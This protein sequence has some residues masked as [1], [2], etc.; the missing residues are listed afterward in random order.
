MSASTSTAPTK[1]QG[2]TIAR[3]QR[4]HMAAEKKR[5]VARQRAELQEQ[6]DEAI[7]PRAQRL[8]VLGRDGEVI[9]GARLERDGIV[10]I[11]SNPI[12]RLV[13]RGQGKDR[14]L[15]V[16]RHADAVE[17]LLRAWEEGGEGITAGVAHYGVKISGS[18]S[19]GMIADGVLT[20]VNR[21]VAARAELEGVKARLGARWG[22]LFSIA[23]AGIDVS[24]W[25]AAV[26]MNPNCAAGY[27]AACLDMLCDFYNGPERRGRIRMVEIRP[28]VQRDAAD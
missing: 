24:A 27:C 18:S 7:A 1:Q 17:R 26:G 3:A 4:R 22:A 20:G 25:G 15:F 19:A 14:P 11:R 16:K 6:R 9:R 2:R 10:F 5:Q 12:K 23:I 13:A 21:Q 28:P 8:P